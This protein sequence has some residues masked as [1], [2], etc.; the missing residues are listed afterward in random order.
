MDVLCW[1]LAQFFLLLLL[2]PP[3]LPS[4]RNAHPLLRREQKM[5]EVLNHRSVVVPSPS[6]PHLPPAGSLLWVERRASSIGAVHISMNKS[7]LPSLAK[8]TEEEEDKGGKIDFLNGLGR[9]NGRDVRRGKEEWVCSL[10]LFYS[11]L[12]RWRALR[13]SKVVNVKGTILRENSAP[14]LMPIAAGGGAFLREWLYT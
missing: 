11:F 5:R 12:F 9:W 1:S 13:R 10:P 3:P 4:A 14:P 7:T 6:F 8:R 2:P